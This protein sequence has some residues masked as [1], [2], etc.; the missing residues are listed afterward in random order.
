MFGRGLSRRPRARHSALTPFILRPSP[1]RGLLVCSSPCPDRRRRRAD[2]VPLRRPFAR[3]LGRGDPDRVAPEDA[4]ASAPQR[5][6]VLAAFEEEMVDLAVAGAVD[7]A[8]LA[9]A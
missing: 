8:A 6:V 2:R 3:A 7:V 1:V 5:R 4:L 9:A